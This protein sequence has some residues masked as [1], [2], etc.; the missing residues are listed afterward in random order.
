MSAFYW[1]L[2]FALG[3]MLVNSVGIW[4]IYKYK[5]W[6]ERAKVYFMCFAAGVLISSP[7][8]MAFPEALQKNSYA[9]FAALAGFI[10][11]FFSNKLI[12]YKTK[13]EGLGFWVLRILK[14]LN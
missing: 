1:I 13:Q 6:A 10:F 2:I 5:D 4:V 11:M 8:I 14:Q 9:G 3:A 12:K 7:L